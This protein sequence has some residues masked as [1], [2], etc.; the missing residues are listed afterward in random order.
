MAKSKNNTNNKLNTKAIELKNSLKSLYSS[1]ERY[2]VNNFYYEL[3]HKEN[4]NS[5]TQLVLS[6]IS[7][8]M[9]VLELGLSPGT[10]TMEAAL[11]RAE[12]IG[13]DAKPMKV[14]IAENLKHIEYDKFSLINKLDNINVDPE[15]LLKAKF[16]VMQFNDL[17]FASDY[18]DLIF[19]NAGIEEGDIKLFLEEANKTLQSGGSLILKINKKNNLCYDFNEAKGKAKISKVNDGLII[20]WAKNNKLKLIKKESSITTIPGT[21]KKDVSTILEFKK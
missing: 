17:E 6:R 20:K 16:S 7:P 4:P 5:F 2:Y 10:L 9:K 15:E 14:V 12:A 8:G 11:K 18:F 13:I 19:S 3:L 1:I 21:S